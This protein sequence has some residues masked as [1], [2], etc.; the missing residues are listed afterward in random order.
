MKKS[1]PSSYPT[2]PA[3]SQLRRA[4]TAWTGAFVLKSP[5]SCLSLSVCSPPQKKTPG[6]SKMPV[7]WKT[8][9]LRESYL[10]SPIRVA[11]TDKLK[12]ISNGEVTFISVY[13]PALPAVPFAKNTPMVE[14]FTVDLLPEVGLEHWQQCVQ[15]ISDA[16]A[17]RAGK[18]YFGLSGGK[19]EGGKGNHMLIAGWQGMDEHRE[20]M[21]TARLEGEGNAIVQARVALDACFENPGVMHVKVEGGIRA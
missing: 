21:G 7:D 9:A 12:E 1:C 13:L 14:I 8:V 16:I 6:L 11:A 5:K 19:L 10:E 3:P 20:L 15:R 17:A 4:S 18:N 2:S